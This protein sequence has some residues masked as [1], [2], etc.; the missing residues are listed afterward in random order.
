M[1]LLALSLAGW[2]AALA[3][4]SRVRRREVLVARA[5]H[6]LRGPLTAARLGLRLVAH[7]ATEPL[8]AVELELV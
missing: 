4:W 5:C 1:T 8:P 2:V 3:A 7:G 6:E